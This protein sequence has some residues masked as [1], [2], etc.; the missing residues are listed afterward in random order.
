MAT[1]ETRRITNA[2][3][4]EY[5]PLL[6]PDGRALVFMRKLERQSSIQQVLRQNLAAD[7]SPQGSAR[8]LYQGRSMAAG[9]AWTPSGKE[10]VFCTSDSPFAGPV[11]PLP[12]QL[13]R[14]SADAPRPLASL[15]LSRTCSGVA[16]SRPDA[17]GRAMLVYSS[18]GNSKS[19]LWQAD[20]GALDRAIPLAPSSRFDGLPSYSPDGS[21]MAFVSN[22]SGNPEIWVTNRNGTGTKKVTEDSHVVSTPRWSPDGSRLLYGAEIPP[23]ADPRSILHGLYI[24]PIV[25][26]APLRVRLGMQ[27]AS[28]PSWSPDGQGIF[29]WSKSQLWRAHADGAGS[30]LWVNIPR[31]SFSPEFQTTNTCTTHG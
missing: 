24:T 11:G 5:A 20:L 10:L 16:I 19:R 13:Y 8:V 3:E 27:N 25:G 14:L 9:L 31:T 29:Y 21:L 18:G 17:S 22:R 6:S 15:G 26:G 23:Q 1:A 28:D 7:G 30:V 12:T 2:T 4:Y